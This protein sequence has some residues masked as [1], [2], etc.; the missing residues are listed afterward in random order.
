MHCYA[1]GDFLIGAA[2]TPHPA[3]AWNKACTFIKLQFFPEAG[4]GIH[5]LVGHMLL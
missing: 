2:S 1:L 5:H 3:I 4:H